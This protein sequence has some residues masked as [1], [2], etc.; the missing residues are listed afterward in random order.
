M[1]LISPSSLRNV[2]SVFFCSAKVTPRVTGVTSS[3]LHSCHLLPCHHC[4]WVHFRRAIESQAKTL[5]THLSSHRV[6]PI[7]TLRTLSTLAAEQVT[8][9]P[10]DSRGSAVASLGHLV[11]L[12][13]PC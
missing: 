6:V 12:E 8:A 4:T 1:N 9:H 11:R 7:S 2:F 13:T 5:F 10:V 3:L